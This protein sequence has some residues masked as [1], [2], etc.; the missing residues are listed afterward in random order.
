VDL[1]PIVEGD[2]LGGDRRRGRDRDHGIILPPRSP[3]L[4]H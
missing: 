2:E 3:M 4:D 1:E